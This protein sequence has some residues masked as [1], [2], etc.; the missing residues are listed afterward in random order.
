MRMVKGSIL[1]AL[2]AATLAMAPAAGAQ[3]TL[4]LGLSGPM[5]GAAA[6]WGLGM[7]AVAKS[8]AKEINDAGGV[9]VG[10]KTY[11]FEILAY[12][13]KYTAAEGTK[14][15]QA[16]VNRDGVRYIAGAIGT[17]PVMALQS[18]TER[19]GVLLFNT[20]WGASIKGPKF[21]LTFTQI[22]TPAEVAPPLYRYIK[23]HNPDVKT[24]LTLSP[25]DATGK[26]TE[27][28]TRRVWE[29]LGLKMLGSDWYERGTT[30]FQPIAAK[31]AALKPDL[32]DLGAA[33]PGDAG[34]VM[35][36][37]ATLGWKGVRVVTA[38][39]N[40]E[41]MV[42]VGGA[43]VE[44]TYL[45]LSADFDGPQSTPAQRRL[46]KEVRAA[47]GEAMN[48]IQLGAYDAIMALRAG[49]LA[50]NSVEP[51][52]IAAVLP[53]IIF[54]ISYGKSAFGGAETYGSPQQMLV[55]VV[56]TQIKG[57]KLVELSRET[58]VELAK[59]LAAGK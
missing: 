57:G 22:N 42:K 2:G 27:A 39:T 52:A 51:K 38:G 53:K 10:G 41:T 20:G 44:G 33:P 54:E 43:A 55:P 46:N 35:K 21:P 24:F 7:E 26:E 37:L 12:D 19:A 47:T 45:G 32:L 49:M 4:K 59:R 28:V 17:A 58:P 40:A 56:V 14:V 48:V 31:I 30:E 9:K 6:V 34:M 36:E 29:S 16:L 8:A 15:A 23:K 25:N 13:N 5:S 11:R 1:A 50:A 18:I 3:E